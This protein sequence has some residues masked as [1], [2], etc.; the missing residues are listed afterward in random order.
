MN[1]LCAVIFVLTLF[2]TS[3]RSKQE[4]EYEQYFNQGQVLYTKH[5]SNCHQSDGKGLGLLYPPLN[6]SDYMQSNFDSVVCIIKFGKTTPTI[7]NGK[8][9]V[10]PMKGVTELTDLD[11]A[12]IATYIYNEW[13]GN[14]GKVKTE[15]VTEAREK[16]N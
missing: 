8:T 7:V 3:C 10:Q 6:Q 14:R 13:G 16:C 5:C 12:E 2:V 15:D 1:K 11:I 4:I 9:Y